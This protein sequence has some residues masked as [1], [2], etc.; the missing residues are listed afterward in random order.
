[1]KKL[2]RVALS[3]SLIWIIVLCGAC[4]ASRPD[5][6]P[7]EPDTPAPAPHDGLFS[8]EHGTGQIIGNFYTWPED[9]LD[10]YC[11]TRTPDKD[12]QGMPAARFTCNPKELTGKDTGSVET[13][14]YNRIN[15]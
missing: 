6:Y 3:V 10:P 15:E 7:F 13:M 11:I 4:A 5:N 8:S 2:L 1:M 9:H 14:R 12:V